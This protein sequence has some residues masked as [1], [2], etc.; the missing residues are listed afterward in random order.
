MDLITCFDYIIR[1]EV[2][3][4][5]LLAIVLFA[6]LASNAFAQKIVTTIHPYY[7]L[8][9]QI[10]PKAEVISLLP[11][12]ASSHS[13]DP[14][15]STVANLITADLIILNGV[16]DEWIYDALKASGSQAPVIKIFE[17]V[18][19]E[20]ILGSDKGGYNSNKNLNEGIVDP[21][22]SR[23]NWVNAHIWLDPALMMQATL[24]I[25]DK[26]TQIDETNAT[27]YLANAKK[28]VDDLVDLDKEIEELLK[29]VK[30]TPFVPFHDAWRYFARH[31]HLNLVLEIQPSQNQT[32]TGSYLNYKLKKIEESGA[33]VLF[34]EEQLPL[35]VAEVFSELTGIKKLAFLDSVGGG[36]ET[37]SY[38]DLL[39]YNAQI[40]SEALK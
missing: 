10:A 18:T 14:N 35:H 12:G 5:I 30:D 17:V 36:E 26:L 29:P 22:A 32:L 20:P 37:R 39:R 9:K 15:P 4:M 7:S 1:E 38:Q 16:I 21:Y 13:F 27:S 2:K 24:I 33:T 40:I 25:A 23:N 28:L 34:S 3:N 8:V 31:Y 11:V 6:C 19:V